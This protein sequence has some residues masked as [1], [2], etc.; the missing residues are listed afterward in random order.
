MPRS[1]TPKT[2][3]HG[4]QVNP[5]KVASPARVRLTRASPPRKQPAATQSPADTRARILDAAY[6]VLCEQGHDKLT[7]LAV[8]KAA[9]I[10]QGHLTY[11]FP[12]RAALQLG[13]AEHAVYREVEQLVRQVLDGGGAPPRPGE[14][15]AGMAAKLRDRNK[16]RVMLGLLIAADGDARI[17]PAV[18]EFIRNARRLIGRILQQCG[19]EASEANITLLHANLIGLAI[20]NFAFDDPDFSASLDQAVPALLKNWEIVGRNT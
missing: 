2:S 17:K 7:Q 12:T 20:L 6:G 18:H 16:P 14:L 1:S 10:S 4:S 3:A 8:C 15:A 13:L 5:P 9:S 11:Y 19:V